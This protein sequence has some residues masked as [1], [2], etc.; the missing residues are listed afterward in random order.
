MAK[1]TNFDM[2]IEVLNTEYNESN[3]ERAFAALLSK[4]S[5]TLEEFSKYLAT[6]MPTV[7]SLAKEKIMGCCAMYSC[8]EKPSN[9]YIIKVQ[10]F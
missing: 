1:A 3:I 5:V 7:E 8:K 4:F 6:S 10:L 2:L 9:H